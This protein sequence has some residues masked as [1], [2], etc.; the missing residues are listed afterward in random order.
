[1]WCNSSDGTT[2]GTANV[3]FTYTAPENVSIAYPENLSYNENV[4]RINYTTTTGDDRCWYSNDSGVTNSTTVAA[5][6]NF[7]N[8]ISV[9]GSNTWTVWCNR[10]NGNENSSSVTFFKDTVAPKITFNHPTNTTYT[11]SNMTFNITT[12]EDVQYCNFSLNSG[13]TNVSMTNVSSMTGWNY[14]NTSIADG[15]YT[16]VYNCMDFYNNTN[17]TANV[18][19]TIDAN[20]PKLT[21]AYPTNTTYLVNVSDLNFTYTESNPDSCWWSNSSGATNSSPIS[22]NGSNFSGLTSNEGSNTW[23]LYCNDTFGNENSTNVTFF[24]DTIYPQVSIVF[25]VNN[26]NYTTAPTDLN[27]TYSDA[28]SD[29]CWYSNDSGTSNSS[30]VAAG[31]NFTNMTTQEGQN[32]WTVYCN[33]TANNQ[34]SSDVTFFVDTIFPKLTIVVPQNITYITNISDLNFTYIETNPGSCWYSNNSGTT[35]SSSIIMN[36]SNFSN[37]ISVEGSNTWILYCNDSYGNENSTNITFTKDTIPPNI[38]IDSPLNQSYTESNISFEV[39]SLEELSYC[40]FTVNNWI[41]NYTMNISANQT[42]TLNLTSGTTT[43]G[44][45]L[46][47]K[48]VY[49]GA[50]ATVQ[51][52]NS[53]SG[54]WLN[55]TAD[56]YIILEGTIDGDSRRRGDVGGPGDGNDG[57][58]CAD[59]ASGGGGGAYGGDGGNG[60]DG[61]GSCSGCTA[62]SASDGGTA[63]GQQTNITFDSVNDQGSNGGD[64]ACYL[65]TEGYGGRGGAAVYLQAAEIN[66]SGTVDVDGQAGTDA[67]LTYGGCGGGGGGSGGLIQIYGRTVNISAG[68]FYARGGGGGDGDAGGRTGTDFGDGGGGAGGGRI[69]VFAETL[70]NSSTTALV[71]GGTGGAAVGESGCPGENGNTGTTYT[72]TT[73]HYNGTQA[74]YYNSS[75]NDGQYT[76]QFWC[77]DSNGNVNNTENVT[78]IVDVNIPDVNITYPVNGTVYLT[79]VTELNYT[80]FDVL[81][82]V[83]WY[84]TNNGTTN[85]TPVAAGTNFSVNASEGWNGW[86][87]YC[88]DTGNNIGSHNITFYQDTTTMQ[89]TI[90]SPSNTTYTTASI[91]FNVTD[92]NIDT[93]LFSINGWVTNYTMTMFNASYYYYTNSSMNDGS[94]NAT[95][96]CNETVSGRANGTESVRFSVDAT[97]PKLSIAYPQNTTY[98]VNVSDLNYTYTESNGD[99]CWYS[100]D[101]GVTN[102]TTVAFGTNFSNVISVEGSNTW[103]LYCNDTFGNQNSTN[104]TFYKDTTPLQITIDSPTNTTYITSSIDFNVS[105][106]D[107]IDFCKFTINNWVTNYTM[108]EFNSSLYNYTNSSMIDGQYT[109]QFWCNETISGGVNDTENVTFTVDTT[110]PQV[111]VVYPTNTT[112]SVNVT[113]LNYT[114]SDAISGA[115]RCWYSN[116]SGA[117]NSSTVAAGTNFT[118]VASKDGSN[119]WIVWCNDTVGN[120]N[121][122]NVTFSRDILAPSV[123]VS[124]PSGVL[125]FIANGTNLS[126]NYSISDAGTLDTC[127]Y[128]YNSLNT[129]INCTTNWTFIYLSGNT[130]LTVWANDTGGLTGH[131]TA[132]WTEVFTETGRVFN[133]Q[134]YETATEQFLLNVTYNSSAWDNIAAY[135]VYNGTQFLST[136]VGSGD[137]IYFD[138]N[139]TIW[140]VSAP[141]NYTFYWSI[142]VTNASGTFTY[143][144]S[145]ST[146]EVLEVLLI[147][148]GGAYQM[149]TLNFTIREEGSETLL[150]GNLEAEFDYWLGDGEY[151]QTYEFENESDN[152]SQFTFCLHPNFSEFYT[153]ATVSYSKEDYDAR[154]YFFQNASL[155]N[156]SQNITLYLALTNATDI[157]TFTV[158]DEN[159][160]PVET[161]LVYVQRWDIGTDT[162]ST[163][164]MTSTNEDG[165]G[166]VNMRLNDAWYRYLVYYNGNLEL[167]FG[168]TKESTTSRTL[169][170]SLT[171]P[172]P[173]LIF[174][175]IN[176]NLSWNNASQTFVFVFADGTGVVNEGCLKVIQA[177]GNYTGDVYFTCLESSSGTISYPVTN[178]GTFIGQGIF[179][180]EQVN[181]SAEQVVDEIIVTVG[182]DERFTTIG[183]FGQAISLLLIG[184]VAMVGVAT[185]SIPLGLVLVGAALILCNLLGWLNITSTVLYGLAAILILIGLS[186]KRG[187]Y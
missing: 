134:T 104:V 83:C 87:V 140:N 51:V 1:M 96:W 92:S 155:T 2:T 27:Y 40:L 122:S 141:V 112:Y 78:F 60:N 186:L 85:S 95:F 120:T 46:H 11:D 47:Y 107:S 33:D 34:N 54:G 131:Y 15:T 137:D 14:T 124:Y 57:A 100:N 118:D 187:R 25:P 64:G 125:G 175:D 69:K 174:D 132:N 164:A 44:G 42:D 19:F 91:D 43:L 98:A 146:Q 55:I 151:F 73:V 31:I 18:T 76:A 63:Y 82:D 177:S 144:T 36:G 7:T 75:M 119:T 143:N 181:G 106:S 94:Y 29:S 88:N 165:E 48:W 58:V 161:A 4:S 129:T 81:I 108:T 182:I 166:I 136:R 160:D 121:S 154:E 167:T 102:S 183:N 37:V 62:G 3:S 23:T 173:Y 156:V 8:V 126:L 142:D 101:S 153:N 158:V 130:S 16:V 90:Q 79:N 170:I 135:L 68:S 93:C 114:V 115:D 111:S 21:I 20:A 10:T 24:K 133:N 77:N 116:D 179:R 113:E 138:N 45:N 99:R 65:G 169:R 35:N 127:W 50:G 117:T 176:F 53:S 41:T 66:I 61:S 84:S 150:N 5:G 157:F 162:F 172:N 59:E 72:T 152:N 89:I 147:E 149:M 159:E 109:A 9:E 86:I 148:C 49:I 128:E 12:S 32:N 139:I 70:D 145:N 38:I 97:A 71:S 185:G 123:T 56:E 178:N 28:N 184:T 74:Y 30:S 26:T 67:I 17:S 80:Y 171:D 39:S 110:P 168:P 13:L 22:M 52:D 105:D 6:T 103:I 163:V 180:L